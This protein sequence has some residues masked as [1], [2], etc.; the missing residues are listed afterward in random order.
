MCLRFRDTSPSWSFAGLLS[1][2]GTRCRFWLTLHWWSNH[3]YWKRRDCS[4][5]A[6]WPRDSGRIIGGGRMKRRSWIRG[7]AITDRLTKCE[8][9]LSLCSACTLHYLSQKTH[10]YASKLL[11]SLHDDIRSA[12]ATRTALNTWIVSITSPHL[13]QIFHLCDYISLHGY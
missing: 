2:L 8:Q 6:Q 4:S 5:R 1:S 3:L 11:R 12:N 10:R 7:K 13:V 9:I